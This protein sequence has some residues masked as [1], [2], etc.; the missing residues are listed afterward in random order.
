MLRNT[1]RSYE[2]Q[3]AML[4]DR[5]YDLRRQWLRYEGVR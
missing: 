3:E 4:K 5:R 1:R 2:S